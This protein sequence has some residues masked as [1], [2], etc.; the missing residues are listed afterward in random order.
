MRPSYLSALFAPYENERVDGVYARQ[1]PRPD[2]DP[3]LAERLRQWSASRDV[4]E[5]KVFVP[6]DP[7]ASRKLF[8]SLPPME[9][10]LSCVFDNVA[11][12]LRRSTWERS[13]TRS[14]AWKA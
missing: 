8:E 3:L 1:F 10:Y 2:C 6:G 4:P 12:S 9:R 5:L 13:A 14:R 11:S 7:E